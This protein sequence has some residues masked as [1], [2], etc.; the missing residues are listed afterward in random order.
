MQVQNVVAEAS[1]QPPGTNL[2]VGE[3]LTLERSFRA[4]DQSIQLQQLVEHR[5]SQQIIVPVLGG[6][7]HVSKSTWEKEALL[8]HYSLEPPNGIRVSGVNQRR[9]NE[10]WKFPRLV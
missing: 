8:N 2:T 7:D 6:Y 1:I 9:L 3:L 10:T 4:S 5:F